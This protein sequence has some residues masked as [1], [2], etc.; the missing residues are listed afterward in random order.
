MA[1]IEMTAMVS[2]GEPAYR[3]SGM[4]TAPAIAGP[5]MCQV[6]RPRR[7]ASRDQ[8]QSAIAAGMYGIAVMRPFW[9]TSNS[10]PVCVWNPSMIVGRKNASA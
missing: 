5:A 10:A 3:A 4:L 7:A 6:R 8:S 9:N 1:V 2:T